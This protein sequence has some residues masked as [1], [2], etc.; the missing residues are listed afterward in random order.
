MLGVED[1]SRD[2]L[3]ELKQQYYT[4]ELDELGESPSYDELARID[5]LVSDQT[6]FDVYEN[7]SF[8]NDDFACTAGEP[9]ENYYSFECD[10]I[11]GTD[12]DIADELR[13]IARAIENDYS[14]G[15]TNR[16]TNW[17]ISKA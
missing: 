1:L 8:T 4:E 17:S 2:Q 13:E 15:I 11:Y 6:I 14:H 7:D 10:E 5:E 12:Q 9:E 3:T 16:G